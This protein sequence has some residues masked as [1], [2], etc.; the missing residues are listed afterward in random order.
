MI[1][2]RWEAR[3]H[4]PAS[5]IFAVIAEPSRY[6]AWQPDVESASLDGDGPARLGARIHQV[7]KVMGRRTEVATTITKLVPAELFALATD[8]G[9]KPAVAQT[10]RLQAEG[11]GCRLEF[12][13]TLDGIP[14]MAE[15][16]AGAQLTR[17]IPQMLERL[18][19]IAANR[20]AAT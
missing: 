16:L 9:A 7:R 10:Y 17:Q 18:A 12:H 13:L 3:Y 8:P 5:T 15:H 11:H 14:T 20:H 1:D 2:I 19:T 4:A 6:P